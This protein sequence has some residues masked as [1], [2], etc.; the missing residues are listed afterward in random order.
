MKKLLILFFFPVIFTRT[1]AQPGC[2]DPQ[3]TNYNP[4]ATSNNGSCLYPAT[5][6]GLVQKANLATPVLDESSGVEFIANGLWTH[7]DSGNSPTLYRV[8]SANGA[9][10]QTVAVSNATNVDWEDITSGPDYIYVGDFGNNNGNRTDLKI[11]RIAKSDLTPGATSVTAGIINFSYS[12]QVSFISAPNNNNFDCESIIFYNDSLHLFSK[13]WVDKQSRHYVLPATPGTYVAQVKESL[14]AANLV[15]GACIQEGGVIALIGYDKSGLF[16]VSIWMLYDFHGGL[17]FNGNKR[18]FSCS[19]MLVNGQTEGIDFK[20]G[21]YGYVSNER[22]QQNPVNIAPTIKSFD[23]APYLPAWFVNPAP[24]ADFS[25]SNDTICKDNSVIFSDLSTQNPVTWSWSFP[26]GTPSSSTLQN[27]VVA[28]PTAGIYAVTLLVSN[29]SGAVDTL[30]RNNYI[31][32]NSLPSSVITPPGPLNFCT[33]GS[34]M[35]NANTGNGLTYQWKKNGNVISGATASAYVASSTGTYKV[36]VTNS[37]GCS[38][39]SS[40]ILVTGPPAATITAGGPL[41]FC[42]GDS[43][44]FTAGNGSGYSWQWKRN[45]TDINGATGISYSAKTSGSYKVVVTNLFSCSKTSNIKNVT[46]SCRESSESGS[47]T[48][49]LM[50][51]PNPAGNE[52][53]VWSVN[54]E[55]NGAELSICSVTGQVVKKFMLMNGNASV[56]ISDIESGFYQLFV[57]DRNGNSIVKKFVK[58]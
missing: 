48:E 9:V 39:G 38:K 31:K 44:I 22:L 27:P 45:G 42:A 29:S 8:D 12:D 50:L 56:D 28:Y 36:V 55:F 35:L 53:H 40:N 2:M 46:V 21:A 54:N 7:N 26:G 17:F 34:V 57:K 11:Y 24:I 16:P 33:G 4:S 51:Y 18:K 6:L 49:E 23:L 15:T 58:N 14:N 25:V 37:K 41:S 52:I 3:A 32:V 5:T 47:A 43:V 20:N 1:F 30:T 19:S 13:D 10:L